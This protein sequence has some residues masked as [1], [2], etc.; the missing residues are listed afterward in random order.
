MND[1]HLRYGNVGF[2]IYDSIGGP[3]DLSPLAPGQ[4]RLIEIQFTELKPL[5]QV[6]S[7]ILVGS[8]FSTSVA[9]IGSGGAAD[10]IVSSQTWPDEPFTE[11]PTCYPKAVTIRNL[12]NHPIT[13]DSG[14]WGNTT[15][16]QAV[17]TFPVTIP[18]SPASV[19]FII[20]YCPDTNSTITPDGTLGIWTSPQVLDTD[21]KTEIPHFDS[22]IGWAVLLSSV[23]E[24]ITPSLEATI[25]PAEDGHSL[26]IVVPSGAIGPLHFE[27]VNVLGESVQQA[28]LGTGTRTLDE[29]ALP[30]GV[31]FYRLTSGQM[32][33]SGKVILGQ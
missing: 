18:A 12:S 19:Q 17:S 3:L 31:Y 23:S 29:S 24:P 8:C 2:S 15:N 25:L 21:G 20:N 16:F 22:L 26:E 7:I 13:I 9:V 4:R 6:D 30:R 27:L 1:L 28:T 33:Q 32:S 11:P 5:S 14:W 10:F